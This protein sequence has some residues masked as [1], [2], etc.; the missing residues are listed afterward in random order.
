MNVSK[1]TE[2]ALNR[3]SELFKTFSSDCKAMKHDLGKKPWFL[4]HGF[5]FRRITNTSLSAEINQFHNRSQAKQAGW[6]GGKGPTEKIHA[7][8]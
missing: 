7:P 5:L 1:G 3:A 6:G 8:C 2:D 4:S